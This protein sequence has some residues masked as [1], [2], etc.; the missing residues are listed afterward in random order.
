MVP[1][2]IE[3]MEKNITKNFVPQFEADTIMD[4]RDSNIERMKVAPVASH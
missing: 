1:P 4:A 2:I 3:E